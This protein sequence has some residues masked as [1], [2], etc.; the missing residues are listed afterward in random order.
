LGAAILSQRFRTPS[1]F[2]APSRAIAT[3]SAASR[4]GG[5]TDRTRSGPR[6]GSPPLC[7]RKCVPR[8]RAKRP[9][10]QAPFR[11]RIQ[12]QRKLRPVD[13]EN[14]ARGA[15]FDP[16][17]CGA[18]LQS[19]RG[20][21]LAKVER[22]RPIGIACARFPSC[23][24]TASPGRNSAIGGSGYRTKPTD[25]LTTGSRARHLSKLAR[26]ACKLIGR[27]LGGG[28]VAPF[29]ALAPSRAAAPCSRAPRPRSAIPAHMLIR[30]RCRT[31]V[32][33][34]ADHCE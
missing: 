10:A 28:T 32:S 12:A 34:A 31:V 25:R 23:E 22:W 1:R 18:I 16:R 20:N 13:I 6:T 9:P 14:N 2:G 15:Q 3:P 19:A 17:S 21:V 29:S 24:R 33:P 7:P 11:A 27:A 5:Q 4:S 8:V 26:D 30:L